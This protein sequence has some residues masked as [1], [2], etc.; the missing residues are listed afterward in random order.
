MSEYAIKIVDER[1][2]DEALLKALGGIEGDDNESEHVN[3]ELVL[4]EFLEGMGC[5]KSANKV[6]EMSTSWWYA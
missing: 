5:T 4:L 1:K 3:A 6:R 2:C